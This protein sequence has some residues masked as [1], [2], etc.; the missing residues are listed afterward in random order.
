MLIRYNVQAS[1]ETAASSLHHGVPLTMASRA[2]MIY[3]AR[4]V[5]VLV[6][7]RGPLDQDR[8]LIATTNQQRGSTIW[9]LL[10]G[11]CSAL[12]LVPGV[13]RVSHWHKPVLPVFLSPLCAV[14]V[15]RGDVGK[16]ALS[17]RV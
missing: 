9:L 8:T 5:S 4:P 14:A 6:R 10:L 11:R 3:V 7:S 1:I 16:F 17:S 13:A 2:T 15:Q 12:T